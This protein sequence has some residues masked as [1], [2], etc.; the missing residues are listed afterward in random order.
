MTIEQQEKT[1]IDKT[2]VLIEILFEI[3]LLVLKLIRGKSKWGIIWAFVTGKGLELLEW[4]KQVQ[5]IID[6]PNTLTKE[7]KDELKDIDVEEQR[8]MLRKLDTF[9]NQLRAELGDKAE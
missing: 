7:L 6:A 5:A 3:S 9:L 1:G 4:A 2:K 8:E